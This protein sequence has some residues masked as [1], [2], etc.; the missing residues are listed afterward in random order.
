MA[1]LDC[2]ETFLS[3]FCFKYIFIFFF[4][5]IYHFLFYF[6]F[7]TINVLV[8]PQRTNYMIFYRNLLKNDIKLNP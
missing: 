7:N 5:Q 8:Q 2:I 1:A 6:I 3:H 4:I